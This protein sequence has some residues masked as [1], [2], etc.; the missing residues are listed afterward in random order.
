MILCFLRYDKTQ[1]S[2]HKNFFPPPAGVWEE[3]GY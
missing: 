3:R 2:Y 1:V